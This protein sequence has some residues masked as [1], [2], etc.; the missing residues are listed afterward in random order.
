MN[1][2]RFVRLTC[3]A[4]GSALLTI[5][6]GCSTRPLNTDVC[7]ANYPFHYVDKGHQFSICLPP[8][9]KMST[10]GGS[11]TFTGFPVPKG[12]NLMAKSLTIAT[13]NYDYLTG[14]KPAGS[15]TVD[16]VVFQRAELQ[17]GSAGHLTLHVIY[18]WKTQGQS[19]HFDF[20]HAA[21]NLA[22]YDPAD[23][24]QEYNRDAQ[25]K[26]TEEIMQTFRRMYHP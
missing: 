12:T 24:P 8:N 16:N 20:A 19:L 21:V 4:L 15:L 3:L 5:A 1:T 17:D 23:R 18:T 13:G 10:P 6:V 26:I 11:T 2:P 7:P 14:A 25:I 9:L 22:V